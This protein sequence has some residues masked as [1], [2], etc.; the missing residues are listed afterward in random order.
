MGVLAL[1]IGP[2]GGLALVTA[3]GDADLIVAEAD[4]PEFGDG[5][6]GLAAILENTNDSLALRSGSH[7]MFSPSKVLNSTQPRSPEG[8]LGI[9]RG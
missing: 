1:G 8:T 7:G 6:I 4:T 9:D 5:L 3:H 2:G